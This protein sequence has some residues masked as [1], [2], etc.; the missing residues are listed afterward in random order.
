MSLGFRRGNDH[1]AERMPP[2]RQVIAALPAP[3]IGHVPAGSCPTPKGLIPTMFYGGLFLLLP[4]IFEYATIDYTE[5]HVRVLT[6]LTSAAVATAAVYADDCIAWYN[7][8]LGLHI[9]LEVSV[10]KVAFDF[11][12]ETSAG[13]VDS[14]R[15]L[16][17]VTAVVIIVHLLP[18]LLCD[19]GRLLTFLA[20]VGVV[21]NAAFLVY[22]DDR[23]LLIVG[24]TSVGLLI[25][26]LQVI[27]KNNNAPSLLTVAR[28]A[29]RDNVFF[30]CSPAN[31]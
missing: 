10:I 26:T 18:F 15:A 8:I 2:A 22:N 16:A 4:I 24:A 6:I 25:S 13:S 23:N 11:Y 12:N 7:M 20:W 21:V 19:N 31:M 5:T 28:E 30:V 3:S 1:I 14:E 29:M 17:L 27:V 9:G